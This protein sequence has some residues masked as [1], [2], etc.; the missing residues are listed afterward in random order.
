MADRHYI[1]NITDG[2]TRSC[3][4]IIYLATFALAGCSHS[5]E[6]A[7]WNRNQETKK[8]MTMVKAGDA[9][10]QTAL[11]QRYELGDGVKENRAK[12][13]KWYRRAIEQNDPLAMFLLGQLYEADAPTAQHYR[14][15]ANLYIQAANMGHAAAQVRL[16]QFYEQGL[17]V[18]QDFAAAAKWYTAAARQWKLSARYPL[19][20][21]YAIG[22]GDG[23]ISSEAI[24]W[25]ERAASL[26]VAE[27]QFD[28]GRA[29]EVGNGVKTDLGQ[30]IGWY[31]KAARQGHGRATDALLRLH[32]ISQHVEFP[33]KRTEGTT[34][35]TAVAR[36][37]ESPSLPVD[38]ESRNTPPP[39][40]KFEVDGERFPGHVFMAHLASYRS[41]EQAESGWK[42]LLADHHT[43]LRNTQMEISKII[44]PKEGI[45]YRV[46]VG[47]FLSLSKVKALCSMLEA[48]SAYCHPLEKKE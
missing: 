29:Y 36:D 34:D 37:I 33:E 20:S 2:L 48:R 3:R 47:P 8:L 45:F 14:Q 35:S 6:E 24:R 43:A 19:G 38:H 18:P 22:R 23:T 13:I 17:G 15:A 41:V 32:A 27:A 42:Q 21:T 7:F 9:N 26:G 4:L 5:A 28:L 30:S 31:Q 1:S 44:L 25:F 46:K 11:G 10:A 12:A 39:L 16:A 40:D